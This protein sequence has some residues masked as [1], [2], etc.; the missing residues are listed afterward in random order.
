MVLVIFGVSLIVLFVG[1]ALAESYTDW[2]KNVGAGLC[3]IGVLS[4]GVSFIAMVALIGN[5]AGASRIDE[6][7]ALYEEQNTKIEQQIETVVA[8]YQEYET[9]IFTEVSP[10][11]AIT[12]VSLYPELKADTLVQSQIDIYVENN[13][14]I[15][16]LKEKAIIADVYKWWL[17]FGG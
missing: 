15:V 13:K 3:A 16:E 14:K 1:L 4:A 9:G 10:E 7:I 11:S 5:V 17:Y 6:K 2:I 12:L 8:Q